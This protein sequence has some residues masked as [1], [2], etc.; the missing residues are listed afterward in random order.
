M[1][2]K[3]YDTCQWEPAHPS[4]RGYFHVYT[5]TEACNIRNNY[6]CT[7]ILVSSLL[8]SHL[9]RST[10]HTASKRYPEDQYFKIQSLTKQLAI[11]ICWS[12]SY[13]LGLA[14]HGKKYNQRIET[15]QTGAGLTLLYPLYLAAVVGG[16]PSPVCVWAMRCSNIL[17]P[18]LGIGA[19]LLWVCYL[20][21][22]VWCIRVD[23]RHCLTC[24]MD[25]YFTCR[26][27]RCGWCI[28]ITIDLW[29]VGFGLE[30]LV[31]LRGTRLVHV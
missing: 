16:Y 25:W 30:C 8:L 3:E 1:E 20:N 26:H 22:R 23:I 19:A 6:R 7:H 9:K 12:F 21:R 11:D 5:S 2:W 24:R 13:K 17:A 27:I 10:N 31:G 18:Y 4:L 15:V 29:S 14:G 28:L